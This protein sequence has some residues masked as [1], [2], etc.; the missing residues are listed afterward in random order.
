MEFSFFNPIRCLESNSIRPNRF[1]P[2]PCP[3]ISNLTNNAMNVYVLRRCI[4]VYLK[5]LRN[6]MTLSA[7]TAD[8][9]RYIPKHNNIGSIPCSV[10]NYS[11]W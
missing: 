2:D 7:I 10:D 11:D 4:S 5:Q 9:V 8:A 1:F 3:F 6:T